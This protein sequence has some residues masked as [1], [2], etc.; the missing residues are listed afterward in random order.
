MIVL[1][2]IK[3]TEK[4]RINAGNYLAKLNKKFFSHI[5]LLLS[6]LQG[7]KMSS[8]YSKQILNIILE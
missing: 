4:E 5:R 8:L 2:A 6:C 1:A 7:A 3:I